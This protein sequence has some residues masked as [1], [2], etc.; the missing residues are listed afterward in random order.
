[1]ETNTFSG[2]DRDWLSAIDRHEFAEPAARILHRILRHLRLHGDPPRRVAVFPRQSFLGLLCKSSKGRTSEWLTWLESQSVIERSFVE[3][4]VR[5]QSKRWACYALNPPSQWCVPWRVKDSQVVSDAEAWLDELS[6][7]QPD[8]F[9]PP[10][11]LSELLRE[12]FVERLSRVESC[13]VRESSPAGN[14]VV[15]PPRKGGLWAAVEAALVPP[16]GT[17]A[18]E[19]PQE[20][21]APVPCEGTRVRARVESNRLFESKSTAVL[22]NR[23]I[24]RAEQVKAFEA[25]SVASLDV[26]ERLFRLIGQSERT[27][28]FGRRWAEAI[29]QIPDALQEA[30]GHT[31]MLQREGRLQKSPAAYLNRCVESALALHYGKSR[32]FATV[33]Y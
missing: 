14:L 22:S 23:V 30:I 20:G 29:D 16:E 19:V 9:P 8:M 28:Q 5:G 6:L 32:S 12:D 3:V 13:A 11:S 4:T 1:M 15:D 10:P 31:E 21:T 27:G 18:E 33:P 25:R 17:L 26:A 7:D 24:D 2:A